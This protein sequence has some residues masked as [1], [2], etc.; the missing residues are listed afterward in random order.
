MPAPPEVVF[1]EWLDADAFSEWMC[2][3]PARPRAIDLDPRIGG[4]LRLDIEEAGRRFY[5]LG[6]YLELDRP[7]RLSFTWSCST[8]LNPDLESVVTVQFEPRGDGQTLMTI[9]HALLPPDLVE[10]HEAGWE[11]IAT[12]LNSKLLACKIVQA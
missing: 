10:Q 1:D 2:P 12:Q 3:R 7:R 8:W 9:E 6:R 5:V 11:R 4:R